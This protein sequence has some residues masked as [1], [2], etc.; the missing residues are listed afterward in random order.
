MSGSR[1]STPTA[2]PAGR[3]SPQSELFESSPTS[4]PAATYTGEFRVPLRERVR[5]MRLSGGSIERPH[6]PIPGPASPAAPRTPPHRATLPSVDECPGAP[7]KAR[8]YR[9]LSSS[10][11]EGEDNED[12]ID[13]LLDR[14]ANRLRAS[15]FGMELLE[16]PQIRIAGANNEGVKGPLGS[17][18][19]ARE[20]PLRNSVTRDELAALDPLFLENLRLDDDDASSSDWST[21]GKSSSASSKTSQDS[22]QSIGDELLAPGPIKPIMLDIE[23]LETMA[24]SQ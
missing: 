5:L 13:I 23:A 16:R 15:Q 7:R 19:P 2:T 22:C 17:A 4:S 12:E 24:A 14:R 11:E 10:S 1:P 6:T 3:P 20:S 9:L 21:S 8:K 18:A